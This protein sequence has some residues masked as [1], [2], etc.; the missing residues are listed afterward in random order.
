MKCFVEIMMIHLKSKFNS[1]FIIEILQI[2]VIVF[3]LLCFRECIHFC[4][5]QCAMFVKKLTG[6]AGCEIKNM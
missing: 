6:L 4:L 3:V 2:G 5:V 1:P